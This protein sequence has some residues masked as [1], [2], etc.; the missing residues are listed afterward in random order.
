MWQK[1]NSTSALMQMIEQLR[2]FFL[3]KP[4]HI[5]SWSSEFKPQPSSS[6]QMHVC[7]RKWVGA[8]WPHANMLHDHALWNSEQVLECS[9]PQVTL[10]C[11]HRAYQYWKFEQLECSCP[12]CA[13]TQCLKRACLAQILMFTSGA[14][15]CP[16]QGDAQVDYAPASCGRRSSRKNLHFPFAPQH[17]HV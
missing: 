3:K 9:C 4:F 13:F 6:I 5:M 7:K 8:H 11:G 14:C 2:D 10:G 1:N 17:G 12:P 15:T 16:R